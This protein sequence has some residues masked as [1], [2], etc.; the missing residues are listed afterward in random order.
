LPTSAV[1]NST[2][3]EAPSAQ[4]LDRGRLRDRVG[5]EL[6]IVRNL[7]IAR[8]SSALAEFGLRPGGY[9][10][11]ALIAA[12][13]GCSQSDLSREIAMDKS[14]VV[15]ILDDLIGKELVRR[16]RSQVD[17]R[18]HD[19][20]LTEKGE[21]MFA[22]MQPASDLIEQ[23]IVEALSPDERAQFLALL[24]RMRIGMEASPLKADIE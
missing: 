4:G 9:T 22:A 23:P 14:A 11:M 15:G 17:R 19:L 7:L 18:R 6:R 24:Q 21:Q 12:N 2:D 13:P 1:P 10:M 16:T 5:P 20:E 3:C 8:V